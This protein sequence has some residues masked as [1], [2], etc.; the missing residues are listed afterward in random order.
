MYYKNLVGRFIKKN[1]MADQLFILLFKAQA[2]FLILVK[3][4]LLLKYFLY[5]KY[6]RSDWK[7]RHLIY[8]PADEI[9][10]SKSMQCVMAKRVQNILSVSIIHL[11]IAAIIIRCFIHLKQ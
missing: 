11:G 7:A 5:M 1:P 8:F 4:C 3:V 2:L 10:F 6:K 9:V